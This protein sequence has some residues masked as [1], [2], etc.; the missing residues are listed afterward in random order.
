MIF[1]LELVCDPAGHCL[2]SIAWDDDTH[3]ENEATV[4]LDYL[5]LPALPVCRVCGSTSSLLRNLPTAFTSVEE[6][7]RSREGCHVL[8]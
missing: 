3:N 6:A 7:A 1:I 2:E 8:R 5:S 4:G